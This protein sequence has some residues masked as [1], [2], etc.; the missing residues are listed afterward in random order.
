MIPSSLGLI[1][2]A[3]VSR[4]AGRNRPIRPG[5]AR[6]LLRKFGLLRLIRALLPKRSP[7]FSRQ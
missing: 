2:R 3:W 1:K 6:I 7:L 5:E 4:G